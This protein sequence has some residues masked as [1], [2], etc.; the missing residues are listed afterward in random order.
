MAQL[1]RTITVQNVQMI[2]DLFSPTKQF[3]PT[4]LGP[5]GPPRQLCQFQISVLFQFRQCRSTMLPPLAPL[6]HRHP[7]AAAAA[8]AA[9][10]PAAA[11]AATTATVYS[12]AGERGSGHPWTKPRPAI[13]RFVFL[14]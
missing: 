14:F 11:A 4:L 13:V 6:G 12:A 1:G 9:T 10:A 7:A 2:Q 5:I 8:A 3:Y